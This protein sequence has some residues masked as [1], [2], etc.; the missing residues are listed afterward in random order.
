MIFT[1]IVEEIG[2]VRHIRKGGQSAQIDIQASQ[3]VQDIKIGDSIAVNG[4]CLTVIRFD[5][6]HF[7]ADVMPETM[8]KTT[9]AGLNPGSRVNLERALRLSDRLGGHIMQGHVD[10]LGKIIEKSALD[11]SFIF[12][13]GAP[14]DLMK[15]IVPKGSI[16]IDGTSLTVVE[17]FDDSFTVSLIPHTAAKTILGNK[18][19]GDSVNLETDIL[20]RYIEKLLCSTEQKTRDPVSIEFLA[21]NGFL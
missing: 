10:G 21:A 9:L 15:F 1:G 14:Q 8:V 11:I 19:A 3:V 4:V 18:K 7:V 16:A 20:G 17:V 2:Q 12:R 6:H 13:I 5:G